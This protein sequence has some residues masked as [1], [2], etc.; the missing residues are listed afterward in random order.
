MTPGVVWPPPSRFRPLSTLSSWPVLTCAPMKKTVKGDERNEEGG[1]K[2]G[3]IFQEDDILHGDRV[4]EPALG[5]PQ[6]AC[7]VHPTQVCRNRLFLRC[8]LRALCVRL[9]LFAQLIDALGRSTRAS[10]SKTRASESR[11]STST[12]NIDRVVTGR[13][14]ERYA[15]GG[16]N[17][18]QSSAASK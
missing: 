11:A 14:P 4:L 2:Y 10:T 3:N 5:C 17:V 7:Y 1:G 6:D 12:T 18:T 13:A 16:Q 9:A 8:F 15:R